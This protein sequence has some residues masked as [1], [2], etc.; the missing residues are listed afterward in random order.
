MNT[1]KYFFKFLV[2]LIYSE[3]KNLK[4]N[5]S[6]IKYLFL[7]INFLKFFYYIFNKNINP[8]KSK[9][10]NNFLH[11]NKK[12][13]EKLNQKS[14][15]KK[16][17]ILIESLI[18]HHS[19]SI[20]N[21]LIGKYLEILT[22][23]NSIGLIRAGDIK[24]YFLLRSF[25]VKK[26]YI[27]KFGGFYSRLKYIFK[28]IKILKDIK[29]VKE[30]YNFKI[31]KIDIGLLTLDTWIRYTKVPTLKKI[32]LKLI[33][34][35]AEALFALNFFEKLIKKEKVT[36]LVQG[37]KQFIPISIL[38]QKSLQKNVRVYSRN[39]WDKITV[40]VYSNFNQRHEQK[41]RFSKKFL[42]QVYKENKNKAIKSID[43]WFRSQ[44]K[45]KFYGRSWASYISNKK[46][47]VSQWRNKVDGT[48]ESKNI[49]LKK[50]I[51]ISNLREIS[52]NDLCKS[53]NWNKN[54]KIVTIFL[55]YMIDGV[56][57]N[58]RKNLFLDNYSWIIQTLKII[59][60]IKNVN[61][62]VKEHPQEIRYNT[63]SNYSK[64]LNSILE[65]NPHIKNSPLDVDPASI[66]KLTDIALTQNGTAG[67][68]YQ[69]FGV[70]TIIS[71]RSF[72][73]HF[74]FS[75]TPKNVLEYKNILKK[76]HLVKK[77][78][79]T[80]I[81]KA[82]VNLYA[83]Y[84]LSLTYSTFLPDNLPQF[85]SQMKPHHEE[86][87]FNRLVNKNKKFNFIKDPFKKMFEKQIFLNNRHTINFNKFITKNQKINDNLD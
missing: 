69:A 3:I 65:K 25:G 50:T 20:N 64:I 85:E 8:V 66:K 37:E 32:D 55:P 62:I 60:N 56:Y 30:L 35:F 19:Y 53:F 44:I 47:V 83:N 84:I 59:R 68:E 5:L 17:T 23:T 16:T 38:F 13:W 72:Y 80:Q 52:K 42:S 12:K 49:F 75:N 36:K 86:D 24:G 31:N 77:P 1:L 82:K 48:E 15:N 11:L 76:I 87:F 45:N 63:K 71:E 73:S 43:T 70:P 7:H 21:M 26:L 74:G 67:L 41:I 4:V 58:G 22:H 54:K 78:T 51:K 9:K 6:Y 29:N 27:Y 39:G 81:I 10:F 18:N 61:W 33:L 79:N 28:S 2:C 14:K 34:F 46:K 57:Q 40:R